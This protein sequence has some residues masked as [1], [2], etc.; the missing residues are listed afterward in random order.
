M[1]ICIAQI[2]PIAGDIMANI[3]KHKAFIDLAIAQEADMILFPELSLTGYEPSL[4]KELAFDKEDTRLADFQRI[5]DE[6]NI[7]IAVGLPIRLQQGV[8]I[9]MLLFQSFKKRVI[10]SKKYLH[11]DEYPFFVAGENYMDL[12]IASTKIGLAICYEIAIREHG[13]TAVENGAKIY[14]ASVAK[15]KMGVEK[16]HQ[17]LATFAKHNAL[18]VLMSNCVG[19]CDGVIAYGKSAIWN[20]KGEL[21]ATLDAEEEGILIYDD[22]S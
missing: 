16:A 11:P 1:K 6:K 10:N 8:G 2:R 21:I 7:I 14:M 20:R 5:S 3:K 12:S 9:G 15:T 4:S 13:L 19:P 22:Q 18:P 17:Q